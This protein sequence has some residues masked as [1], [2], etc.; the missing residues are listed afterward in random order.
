MNPL[1][2]KAK[3][4]NPLALAHYA[5]KFVRHNFCMIHDYYIPD[6][7]FVSMSGLNWNGRRPL[8]SFS[9]GWLLCTKRTLRVGH[10]FVR[11]DHLDFPPNTIQ[12]QGLFVQRRAIIMGGS[13]TCVTFCRML[14]II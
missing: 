1:M 11:G 7:C 8:V 5:L 4:L 3:T 6:L 9:V 12:I 13:L 10:V 2:H 14:L